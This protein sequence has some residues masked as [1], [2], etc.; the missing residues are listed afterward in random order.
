MKTKIM[1]C[2]FACLFAGFANASLITNGNFSTG[3]ISGWNLTGGEW[4]Q[5]EGGVFREYDNSGWAVL[6]QN[7]VTDSGQ[8]YNISFDTFASYIRGNDFAWAIDGVLNSIAATTQWVTN[9]GSFSATGTGTNVALYMATDPGTGTWRLDNISVT[10]A[11]VAE[12]SALILLALGLLM[13]G[14]SRKRK[15]F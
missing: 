1:T 15:V 13:L 14:Y 5:V 11:S 8:A 10:A 4:S 9:T 3:D 12:P 6:S 7:I 2:L